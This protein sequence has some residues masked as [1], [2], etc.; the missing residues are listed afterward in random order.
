MRTELF[1]VPFDLGIAPCT[2]VLVT[3]MYRIQIR[4]LFKLLLFTYI[5]YYN[6][7][8]NIKYCHCNEDRII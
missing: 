3:M 6:T 1:Y 8:N 4:Y 7:Y 5:L 2:R